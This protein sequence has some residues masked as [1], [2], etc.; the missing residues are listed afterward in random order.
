[1]A[2]CGRQG[3]AADAA[4]A[5]RRDFSSGMVS[6]ARVHTATEPDRARCKRR[7]RGGAPVRIRLRRAHA[8]C[9]SI[10]LGAS[11]GSLTVRMPVHRAASARVTAVVVRS[12]CSG[13]RG[14][15]ACVLWGF[16]RRVYGLRMRGSAETEQ[17]AGESCGCRQLGI[18]TRGLA[19]RMPGRANASDERE[20]QPRL[21]EL[22]W[23][24]WFFW[25]TDL[26]PRAVG[27]ISAFR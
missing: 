19:R 8:S 1:M 9:R 20:P 14:Q 13:D 26:D 18:W 27:D 17:R 5:N 11:T 15:R 22:L 2:A 6:T 16:A 10:A 4:A 21:R 12:R 23:T 7:G 24:V 25:G 3:E